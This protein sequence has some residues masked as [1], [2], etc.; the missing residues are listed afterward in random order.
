M[1][2]IGINTTTSFFL[3]M[4]ATDIFFGIMVILLVGWGILLQ[5][6]LANLSNTVAGM[7]VLQAKEQ[8]LFSPTELC[9]KKQGMEIVA[10]EQLAGK[11]YVIAAGARDGQKFLCFYRKTG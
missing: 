2:Q 6:Q 7:A 4:N 10:Q 3:Q 9:E 8:V 5:L 11:E 1:R